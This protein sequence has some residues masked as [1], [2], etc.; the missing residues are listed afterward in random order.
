[1]KPN[2]S[3]IWTFID[4]TGWNII[5]LSGEALEASNKKLGIE[6]PAISEANQAID[7][8]IL[9]SL[10]KRNLEVADLLFNRN[11]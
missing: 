2:Y 4:S 5:H 1:M 11:R 8:G 10:H 7:R 3:S 9:Q 6:Y